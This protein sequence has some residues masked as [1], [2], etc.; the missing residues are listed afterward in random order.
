M[1]GCL[2]WS[3]TIACVHQIISL[4]F[5]F[6]AFGEQCHQRNVKVV[7]FIRIDL[8]AH[9]MGGDATLG[10]SS[11]SGSTGKLMFLCNAVHVLDSSA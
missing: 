2:C 5:S 7:N 11:L 6:L 10:E 4:T 8:V 9:I 3:H 1:E